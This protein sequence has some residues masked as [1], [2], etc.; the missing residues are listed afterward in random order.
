MF[1]TRNSCHAKVLLIGIPDHCDN[2]A[3]KMT[4]KMGD[5]ET[6]QWGGAGIRAIFSRL[7]SGPLGW[8]FK[9]E[10]S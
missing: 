5:S 9:L 7:I 4:A 6:C 8:L 1:P 3:V 10:G 2:G